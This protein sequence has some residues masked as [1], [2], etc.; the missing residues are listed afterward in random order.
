MWEFI[1]SNWWPSLKQLPWPLPWQ[2]WFAVG[3]YGIVAMSVGF[4][5]GL[6]ELKFLDLA[7]FWFLPLSLIVFP[8]FLEEA[9]FRGLIIP[10]NALDQGWKQSAI[11]ITLSSILFT[12]WHPLNALT[13]NPTAKPYF[14]DVPFLGIVFCLGLACGVAYVQTRSLWSAV[15]IH[16]M[17]VVIWVTCLGGRNLILEH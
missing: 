2:T 17:T 12:M 5:T 4:S 1:K 8:S 15:L 7:K 3:L 16:W 10:R 9:F 13:I 14:L 6:F 11:W